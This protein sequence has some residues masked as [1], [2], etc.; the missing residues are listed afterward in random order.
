MNATST[1][2]IKIIEQTKEAVRFDFFIDYIELDKI[3][4]I[5]RLS[6]V[7][8]CSFKMDLFEVDIQKS[9]SYNRLNYVKSTVSEFLGNSKPSNQFSSDRIVVYGCHC[10][11]DYCGVISLKLNFDEKYAY[12]T[13]IRFE[14]DEETETEEV[15]PLK[16]IQFD[17]MKYYEQFQNFIDEHLA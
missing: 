4:N 15:K 7:G 2:E 17:K 13:D 3:L 1:L 8:F 10:G 6:N 16:I 11:C 9:N 14:K 5:N 12:W